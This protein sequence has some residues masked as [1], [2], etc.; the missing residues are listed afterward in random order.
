MY[1][2]DFAQIKGLSKSTRSCKD[3]SGAGRPHI[4]SRVHP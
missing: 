3:C 2:A 1:A 4:E